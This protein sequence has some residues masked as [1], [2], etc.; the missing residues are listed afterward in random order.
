MENACWRVCEVALGDSF[1]GCQALEHAAIG[2][3]I[4]IGHL[5]S[6]CVTY[7]DLATALSAKNGLLGAAGSLG[8]ASATDAL[9]GG[10]ASGD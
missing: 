5:R 9:G 1:V 10:L 4:V 2:Q 7:P 8:C 3:H 6:L